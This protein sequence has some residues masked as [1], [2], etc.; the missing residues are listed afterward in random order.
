MSLFVYKNFDWI[1]KAKFWKVESGE[2]HWHN[3]KTHKVEVFH[4]DHPDAGQ[5]PHREVKG[6]VSIPRNSDARRISAAAA[7]QLRG[8]LPNSKLRHIK[9]IGESGSVLD[10]LNV[11]GNH[12]H[13]VYSEDASEDNNV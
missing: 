8:K 2:L 6:V 7:R 10:V 12:A 5:G 9:A 11:L 3:P 1:Y 4:Q 13:I